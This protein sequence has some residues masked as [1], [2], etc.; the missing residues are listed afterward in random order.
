MDTK[1]YVQ[2]RLAG[3][4]GGHHYS[5]PHMGCSDWMTELRHSFLKRLAQHSTAKALEERALSERAGGFK[6]QIELSFT[7]HSLSTQLLV[8]SNCRKVSDLPGL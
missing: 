4:E 2:D 6:S 7:P 5:C 3:R 8:Q 1:R